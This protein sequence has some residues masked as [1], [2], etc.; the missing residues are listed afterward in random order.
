LGKA[1]KISPDNGEKYNRMK[2]R[3]N[4]WCEGILFQPDQN[5]GDGCML[6]NKMVELL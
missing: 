4:Y 5:P 2:A 3:F 6:K 1:K